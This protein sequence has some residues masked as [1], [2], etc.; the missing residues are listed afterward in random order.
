MYWGTILEGAGLDTSKYPISSNYPCII[1]DELT[2]RITSTSE[3]LRGSETFFAHNTGSLNS[4]KKLAKGLENEP[5]PPQI[6]VHIQPFRIIVYVELQ[7]T[8]FNRER[9]V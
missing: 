6:V 3:V 4:F 9:S 7:K 5:A 2:R 1:Y 8:E